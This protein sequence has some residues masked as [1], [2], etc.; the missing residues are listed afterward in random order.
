[1]IFLPGFGIQEKSGEIT[2]FEKR[3]KKIPSYILQGPDT[4]DGMLR[5]KAALFL[6]GQT[7]VGEMLVYN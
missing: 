3:N 4:L 1:M 7:L 5:T 2:T 6:S